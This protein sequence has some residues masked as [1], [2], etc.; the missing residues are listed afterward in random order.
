MNTESKCFSEKDFRAFIKLHRLPE[1][2][3]GTTGK[4]FV[5]LSEWVLKQ[6]DTCQNP[7]FTLGISGAQGTGKSTLSNFIQAYLGVTRDMSV[8]CLS[9]DDIYLSRTERVELSKKIH[10]LLFTRG[11]PGT[12]DIKLG[13]SVLES[14][15]NLREGQ[16]TFMPRFNKA[17]DDRCGEDNWTRIDGPI[18][19]VIFE[20]WCVG[21]EAVPDD[22]LIEPINTLESE[23][24]LDGS[25][26]KYV[27]EQLKSY[28]ILFDSLDTLAMLRA[29]DFESVRRWRLEQERKLAS[30]AKNL[31][32]QIMNDDQVDRFVQY[33]ERITLRDLISVST[34]ADVVLD[35]GLNHEIRSMSFKH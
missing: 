10:P 15:R 12:H 25:W 33:F 18:D 19:L 4:Y 8:A 27:N 35:L 30:A 20:G 22:Q 7:V 34:K 1:S 11:V 26:R 5:S 23:E 2:F 32:S 3:I 24:D 17:L 9:I 16:V 29:P 21:S 13:W 14:L 6:I 31:N 28:S